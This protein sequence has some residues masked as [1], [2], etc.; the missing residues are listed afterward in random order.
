M[1]EGLKH[2]DLVFLWNEVQLAADKM[3]H[4]DNGGTF[5][6]LTCEEAEALACVFAAAGRPDVY[7]FIIEEHAKDDDSGEVDFHLAMRDGEPPPNPLG[8]E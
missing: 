3:L 8:K 7:D 5:T 6:T 1:A 4:I 2:N